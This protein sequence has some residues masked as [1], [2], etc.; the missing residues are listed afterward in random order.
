L[1][2]DPNSGVILEAHPAYECSIGQP[3]AY[4]FS[5]LDSNGAMMPSQLCFTAPAGNSYFRL[6]K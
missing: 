4:V 2:A 1:A 6:E 5:M 3:N